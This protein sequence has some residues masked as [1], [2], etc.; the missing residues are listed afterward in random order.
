MKIMVKKFDNT[1]VQYDW[2]ELN[3]DK[4]SILGEVDDLL[5]EGNSGI[6]SPLMNHDMVVEVKTTKEFKK[7]RQSMFNYARKML[8]H[9]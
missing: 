8:G 3:T 4:H 1:K 2:I 5:N 6:K 9:Y 7:Q